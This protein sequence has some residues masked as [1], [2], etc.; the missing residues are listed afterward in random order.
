MTPASGVLLECRPSDGR[1][2]WLLD[3]GARC[4]TGEEGPSILLIESIS[5]I[6]LLDCP[7]FG[8]W[9]LTFCLGGGRCW[10]RS[11]FTKI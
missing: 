5:G 8:W 2:D 9:F 1:S 3:H 10:F 7:D 11:L 4:D 6:G